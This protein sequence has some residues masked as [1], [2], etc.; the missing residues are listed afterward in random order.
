MLQPQSPRSG[1]AWPRGEPTCAH[2]GTAL[3][4]TAYAASAAG[5]TEAALILTDALLAA[6]CKVLELKWE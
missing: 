4:L 6:S 2:P 3:E 5:S 1:P